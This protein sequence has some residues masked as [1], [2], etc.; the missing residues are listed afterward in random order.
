MVRLALYQAYEVVNEKEGK[1]GSH[2][3]SLGYW[4]KT[5]VVVGEDMKG[6]LVQRVFI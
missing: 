2:R 4:I 6:C 3:D 5:S 1:R